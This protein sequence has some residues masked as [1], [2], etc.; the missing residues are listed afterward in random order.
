MSFDENSINDGENER[1][2]IN[3]EIPILQLFD[4]V[5]EKE[6]EEKVSEQISSSNLESKG[7]SYFE[8]KK[9]KS[10]MK[11]KPIIQIP[12]NE[13]RVEE[14]EHTT[15]IDEDIQNNE[16][17]NFENENS[18]NHKQNKNEIEYIIFP[19]EEKEE[20]LDKIKCKTKPID[21][22]KK[23]IKGPFDSVKNYYLIKKYN[24]IKKKKFLIM[25]IKII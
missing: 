4:E 9:D 21:L 12:I 16:K 6:I 18:I 15:D 2:F 7:Y 22:I 11:S 10:K 17:E 25:K 14:K 5:F 1:C 8:D 3:R 24:Q 13:I 20:K 19:K 23:E